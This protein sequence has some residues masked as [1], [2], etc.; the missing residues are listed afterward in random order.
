M[1]LVDVED[2]IELVVWEKLF[3]VI[4]LCLWVEFF[5]FLIKNVWMF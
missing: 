1:I 3:Y 5:S 4:M 2:M